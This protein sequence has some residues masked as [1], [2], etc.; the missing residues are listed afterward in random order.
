MST[1][2]TNQTTASSLYTEEQRAAF[3][4]RVRDQKMAEMLEAHN[5][6]EEEFLAWLKER[7]A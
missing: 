1:D 6:S 7:L 3:W 5:L 2:P 4:L